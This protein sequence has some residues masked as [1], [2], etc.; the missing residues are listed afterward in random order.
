MT[1][2]DT[3]SHKCFTRQVPLWLM[4]SWQVV[5]ATDSSGMTTA[6]DESA[7]ESSIR[8]SQEIARHEESIAELESTFGP[9]DHRLLE[10]LQGLSDLL[11][12]AG[13]FAAAENLLKRQLQLMHITQ[14]PSTLAQT[15]IIV[16]L[17]KSDLR[18][19]DWQSITGR[20]EHLHLIHRQNRD[21]DTATLL[22]TLNDVRA[23]H[24]A[25]LYVDAAENRSMHIARS[26]EI[27]AQI[28]S[29][30][31]TKYG[32]GQEQLI[33]WLYSFAVER[34]HVNGFLEAKGALTVP[35]RY[36]VSRA[37]SLN[38]IE[39]I[40]RIVDSTGDLEARAMAML[41]VADFQ[42]LRRELKGNSIAGRVAPTNR[43]HAGRT[44]RR[45]MEMLR[46]AGVAQERIDAFFARPVALPVARFHSS[47]ED[48]LAQQEQDGY[49]LASNRE[50]ADRGDV[51]MGD[52]IAA[53]DA[54]PFAQFSA[55]PELLSG[56]NTE[57]N[58]VTL[59]FSIDS[60]GRS[61]NARAMVADSNSV[62]VRADAQTAIEKMQFRPCYVKG[63]WRRVRDV[64]MRYLSPQAGAGPL[65]LNL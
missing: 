32:R 18:R 34:Y 23:W 42:L 11:Q 19:Q 59:Q 44:Y 16:E 22:N 31:V 49:S 46:E 36:H 47:L 2:G 63:R 9:Y 57:L 62:A 51:H 52:F 10:P 56:L 4:L 65:E 5:F 8:I 55:M 48:A 20:F 39:R 26:R 61:R 30:A 45:A 38:L 12:E 17:I 54:L 35:A 7:L 21:V 3:H 15:P 43:G 40:A 60:V 6:S 53:N 29:L 27:Q 58:S 28:L 37:A 41:Y 33:P 64:T 1:T 24:L 13:D 50:R 14:G 25:S